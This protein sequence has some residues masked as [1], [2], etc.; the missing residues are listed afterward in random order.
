M[1]SDFAH[2][3]CSKTYKTLHLAVATPFVSLAKCVA[4]NIVSIT[5]M[6]QNTLLLHF[7]SP[8]LMLCLEKKTYHLLS[9]RVGHWQRVR[10]VGWEERG[11]KSP[12]EQDGESRITSW[13]KAESDYPLP[14]MG[15]IWILSIWHTGLCQDQIKKEGEKIP[16][17]TKP[18]CVKGNLPQLIHN[19]PCLS[20]GF[21]ITQEPGVANKHFL[22]CIC[23]NTLIPAHHIP[24]LHG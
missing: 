15:P 17:L 16:S 3:N 1:A 12:G 22:R 23:F 2:S 21:T 24:V 9:G 11:R 5:Y 8:S 18:C 19:T 14:I 10:E 13:H 6:A 4:A 20:N 7:L